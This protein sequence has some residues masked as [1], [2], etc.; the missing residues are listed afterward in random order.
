MYDNDPPRRTIYQASIERASRR[1]IE[2]FVGTIDETGEYLAPIYQGAASMGESIAA[3][4]HG[5]FLIELIQNANDV[6]PDDRSDG[7]IEVLFDQGGGRPGILYV[8]NRGKPFSDKN[9]DALRNM[10][11]SSKPPGEAIGNKGLGFRRVGHICDSPAIFSQAETSLSLDRFTG[12]SFR[13][14]HA[15]DLDGLIADERQR[16]LARSDLPPFHIPIWLDDQPETVLAFARRGFA[17]VIALP[18]RS[19]AAAEDVLGEIAD[20]KAQKAPVLLFLSRLKRLKVRI[21]DN[22]GIEAEALCLERDELAFGDISVADLA[23]AGRYAILR[24][25]I[26]E[27]EMAEAVLDGVTKKQL[28]KHWQKWE[29]DGEVALAVRLD[30]V[31]DTPR[32]YTFLPMGVEAAAPLP[33]HLHGSFFP[34]SNRKN[35]DASVRLNAILLRAAATL[36]GRMSAR[37]AGTASAFSDVLEPA[38]RARAVVDLMCWRK[39]DSLQTVE[40]LPAEVAKVIAAE[41]GSINLARAP[42]V[43]V[44]TVAN[45]ADAIGWDESD[46]PLFDPDFSPRAKLSIF[47]LRAGE[48]VRR[49][50]RESPPGHRGS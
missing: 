16:E 22:E 20:L 49:R 21:I 14:A 35:L 45:G 25:R 30:G 36:A 29:G 34:S 10:G 3:D 44:L 13:F 17:T 32:L 6:H 4:Y 12:Y 11:L 48:G 41:T 18:V 7:E 5:R 26:P 2:S 15:D 19:Q 39:V 27:A 24:T 9:V 1:A 46:F 40:D 47:H 33:G 28:H 38:E 31:V 43:P 8:A 42:V 50:N 23:S 37:L